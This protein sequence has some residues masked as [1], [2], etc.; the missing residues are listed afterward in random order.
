MRKY[1]RSYAVEISC[2]MNSQVSVL[3]RDAGASGLH[4]HVGAWKMRHA[5]NHDGIFLARRVAVRQPF[6]WQYRRGLSQLATKYFYP[7]FDDNESKYP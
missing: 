7:A 4:S 5:L 1:L 6:A 2:P 3:T